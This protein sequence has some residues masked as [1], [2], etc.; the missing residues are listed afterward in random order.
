M[1]IWFILLII[2]IFIVLLI[3]IYINSKTIID[4]QFK[5]DYSDYTTIDRIKIIDNFNYTLDKYNK[6]ATNEIDDKF[7][8]CIGAIPTCKTGHPIKA[9][10]YGNGNTYKSIC[11]DGSNMVC[12]NFVSNNSEYNDISDIYVWKTPNNTPIPF[13]NT[14][15]GFTV[16]TKHIPAVIN[17]NSINFYDKNY[18]I[19]DTINKCSLVGINENNCRSSLN[20]PFV[21]ADSKTYYSGRDKYNA[22]D[23]NDAVGYEKETPALNLGKGTSYTQVVPKSNGKSG[24]YPSLPCIAD[25]GAAPGDNVCNGEIGLIQDETLICPYH[26]PICS[27]YRCDSKFGKCVDSR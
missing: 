17:N 3:L 19:I 2:I 7:A 6:Y 26:K 15:K 22:K 9:G 1:Y 11:D 23:F 8:Y 27:G 18:N 16:P 13:S 25:Y 20:I 14:Y 5:P 12:N 10:T 4:E 21:E 24:M